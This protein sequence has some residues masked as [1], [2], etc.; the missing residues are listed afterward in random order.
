[1]QIKKALVLFLFFSTQSLGSSL[2]MD[3]EMVH[4]NLSPPKIGLREILPYRS[5]IRKDKQG[6]FYDT[7][8]IT[9]GILSRNKSI[10]TETAFRY[11][12]LLVAAGKEFN[13]SPYLLAAIMI[14]ESN[15]DR[16]AASRVAHGL[17]QIN[18]NVHR[19]NISKAFPHIKTLQ[20]LLLPEN[21]I[22]VGAWLFSWH[23]KTSRKDL[24]KSLSL[25]LG[26]NS[27]KYTE[28]VLRE[29]LFFEKIPLKQE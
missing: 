22:R 14:V 5:A 27:I 16:F 24:T 25:Y 26:G 4:A 7:Q 19:S 8:R 1:M 10:D 3:K 11:A 28:K 29:K 12:K 6:E 13:L 20:D 18:W 17:M 2:M 21:N 23:M 9:A 15:G